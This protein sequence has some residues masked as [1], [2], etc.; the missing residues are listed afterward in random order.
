MFA[1]LKRASRACPP[2]SRAPAFAPTASESPRPGWTDSASELLEGTDIVE[3]SG[4]FAAT[5]LL[6]HFAEP[7]QPAQRP[8]R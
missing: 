4:D 7:A 3:Y 5:V 6:E 2:A 8:P 1:F